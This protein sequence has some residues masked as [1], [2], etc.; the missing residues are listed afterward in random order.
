MKKE[1][2]TVDTVIMFFS[3]VASRFFERDTPP[4]LTMKPTWIDAAATTLAG[5]AFQHTHVNRSSVCPV[6]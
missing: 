6:D 4:S 2:P 1:S 5:G 3:I